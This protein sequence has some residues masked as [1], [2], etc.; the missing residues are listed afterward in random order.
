MTAD[1]PIP[2]VAVNCTGCGAC[3]AA[4]AR[5]ALSLSGEAPG[6]HGRKRA[7]IDA[8]RCNG[9]GQCVPACPR[10]ALTFA[11]TEA[12]GNLLGSIPGI[13][14][15]E[16]VDTLSRSE[17]VRIERIV[18][19]GHV[20]PA[21]FWYDQAEREFVLLVDGRARLAFADGTPDVDLAPGDW[22]AIPAHKKHRVEWTDPVQESVWLAVFYRP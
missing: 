18:S 15:E 16:L 7:V 21:G 11:P 19:H 1:T 6:Q 4:C 14:P 20:S 13:L 10:D 3:V 22:L 2:T 17:H 12:A 8:Q 9:C 5:H